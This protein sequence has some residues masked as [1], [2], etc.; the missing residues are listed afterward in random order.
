MSAAG[1]GPRAAR[2]ANGRSRERPSGV[3]VL[4]SMSYAGQSQPNV[5]AVNS[6]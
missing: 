1:T 2:N 5:P 3:E 6:A 4:A